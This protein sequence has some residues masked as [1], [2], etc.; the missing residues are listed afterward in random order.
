MAVI[1][2]ETSEPRML[3]GNSSDHHHDEH[4]GLWKTVL[5]YNDLDLILIELF[6]SLFK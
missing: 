5:L 3:T 2:S 6:P 1:F 4:V